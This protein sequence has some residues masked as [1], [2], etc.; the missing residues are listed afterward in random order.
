MPHLYPGLLNDD[1][2]RELADYLKTDVFKCGPDAPQICDVPT[3]PTSRGTKEWQAIYNVITSP[4]CINCHT[5][6]SAKLPATIQDY[7][8]QGDDRHSHYYAVIRGP[9]AENIRQGE[10]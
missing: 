2:V 5:V 9:E 3:Y 4:R 6:A 7:P 1:D 8:R 10:G